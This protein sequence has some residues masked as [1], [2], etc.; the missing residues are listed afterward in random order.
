MSNKNCSSNCS[1]YFCVGTLPQKMAIVVVVLNISL[2]KHKLIN[3]YEQLIFIC[4][5]FHYCNG[6]SAH[7]NTAIILLHLN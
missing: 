6:E 4:T 7:S 3:I 5:V 1:V 2:W